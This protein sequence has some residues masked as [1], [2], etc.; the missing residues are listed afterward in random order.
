M[1]GTSR[2][3]GRGTRDGTEE[4]KENGDE[5]S[6]SRE[7]QPLSSDSFALAR[8]G[9]ANYFTGRPFCVSFEITYS[10]NA[11]CKHCH[12]GGA[13]D[14]VRA[15]AAEYGRLSREL[16]PVVGQ[17]SG[18][19]PLLRRDVEQVVEAIQDGKGVPFVVLTTNGALLARAKYDK[20][21]A[22]GVDEFS[23]SL[24]YP[25]ERH[26]VFR[27]I[28]GLFGKISNLAASLRDVSDT[29]I[30]L[31]CVVQR[32]NFREMV[33]LADLARSWNFKM[34]FSTYTPLRTHNL[35]Y[36][37]PPGE[38][39]ELRDMIRRVLEHKRA[40]GTVYTSDY[41]FSRMP[42]YFLNSSIP[43]CRAGDRFFVVNPDGTL[44]PCGLIIR[45]YKSQKEIKRL[46]L[47]GNT[48]AECFTSIRANTEKPVRYAV[49]DSY[50][51]L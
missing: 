42:E 25:D 18:G 48:C 15:T 47:K 26:D 32:D 41:V 1:V 50:K 31:S 37:V 29:K 16:K 22:A 12:L 39:D 27:G 46:F 7:D 4:R 8:R 17:V 9:I 14:E 6:I 19:E 3:S 35:D 49:K 23:L 21:R 5:G 34:N 33:R 36:M 51:K 11:R 20:L 45:K 30:T 13:V 2:P 38:I 43:G 24:D 44:S 28:P 10:C 40:Y